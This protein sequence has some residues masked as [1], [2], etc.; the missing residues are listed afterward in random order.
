M[1]IEGKIIKIEDTQT[2]D[3]GFQK[4]V[5][6]VEVGGEY[7][8]Q[9]PLEFFKDKCSILDQYEIGQNV[10]VHF[11]LKGSEYNGK[12]YVNLNAWKINKTEETKI[13]F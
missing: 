3:S 1:N 9:I 7:P 13:P 11:N 2:F 10:D 8:Q 5:V 4:R 6:V 12:Y